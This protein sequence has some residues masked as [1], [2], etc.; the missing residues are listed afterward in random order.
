MLKTKNTTNILCATILILVGMGLI[1]GR[2]V[3]QRPMTEGVKLLNIVQ[4]TCLMKE[5]TIA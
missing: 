3:F 1:T 2:K 5:L 4:D